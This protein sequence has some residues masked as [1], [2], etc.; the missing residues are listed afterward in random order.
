MEEY[1]PILIL[2]ADNRSNTKIYTPN[3]YKPRGQRDLL[4]EANSTIKSLFEASQTRKL[5][6]KRIPAKATEKRKRRNERA[7]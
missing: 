4:R 5:L 7:T 6:L 3:V 2:N 1:R